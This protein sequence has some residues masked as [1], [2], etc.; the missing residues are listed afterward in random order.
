MRKKRK[1][2]KEIK[3]IATELRYI[4]YKSNKLQSLIGAAT[5]LRLDELPQTRRSL[6]DLSSNSS[7]GVYIPIQTSYPP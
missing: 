5:W 4:K 2:E 3:I 6:R 1:K 7:N